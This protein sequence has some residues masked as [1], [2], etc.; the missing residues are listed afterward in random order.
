MLNLARLRLL[1]ELDRRGTMA[2]VASELGYTPSAISQQL[3]QLERET[4]RVLLE[5]AG[6]GLRL[7][8]AGRLLAERGRELIAQSESVEADLAALEG[9]AGTLRVAAY[10]TAARHLVTPAMRTLHED[11]PALTCELVDLDAEQAL[12]LLRAGQLDV[13][14]AEEYEHAPRPRYADVER[15]ELTDDPL[16]LALAKG[17][18]LARKRGRVELAAL[19]DEPWATAYEGTAY[20]E[21]LVR[22]CRLRGGFEPI[23]RHRVNDMETL[24]EL[25]AGGLAVIL[26]PSLGL[27]E[28]HPG[29]TVRDLKGE[30]VSR[31]VFAATRQGAAERPAVAA[32]LAEL[33]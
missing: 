32:L 2:A 26:A 25:A 30:P 1:V 10:Q 9:V 4:G 33:G 6:R 31:S 17:H 3:G 13:V 28:D 21:M 16:R 27:P 11:H 12:P 8:D 24:L 15:H 5:K 19:R 18:P 7:T 29:L 22:T 20:S 14:V 23:I